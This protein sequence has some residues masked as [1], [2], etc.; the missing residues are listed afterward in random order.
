[1]DFILN[2]KSIN[3]SDFLEHMTTEK[4]N[5]PIIEELSDK[6]TDISVQNEE[7]T[8]IDET[9]ESS[10][11]SIEEE[12]PD[13]FITE[14]LESSYNEYYP[15]LL[16]PNLIYKEIQKEENKEDRHNLLLYHSFSQYKIIPDLFFKTQLDLTFGIIFTDKQERQYKE[17]QRKIHWKFY[18]L[19]TQSDEF[20][21]LVIEKLIESD[22]PKLLIYHFLYYKTKK[23][24]GDWEKQKEEIGIDLGF[25]IKKKHRELIYSLFQEIFS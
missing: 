6:N 13:N 15:Q 1:M 12:I 22:S 5:E 3:L 11:T 18:K 14:N 21:E 20:E 16:I 17:I 19:L 8:S 9:I 25:D 2:N 24:I 23:D 4:N 10:N 7:D